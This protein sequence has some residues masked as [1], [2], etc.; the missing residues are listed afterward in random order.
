MTTS[1][2]GKIT[3]VGLGPGHPDQLTLQA[4]KFLNTAQHV[5]VRTERHPTLTAFAQHGTWTYFDDYYE[6]HPD[7]ADVYAAIVQTLITAAQSGQDLA[8]A[9]PGHPHVAE[10]TVTLLIEAAQ[11]A[12]IAYDV[13][14]GVSFIEP[15]LS[16]LNVDALPGLVI[17]DALDVVNLY[18][19]PFDVHLPVLVPQLYSRL[20][21]SDV[22]MTLMN[23]YPDEHEV[24][25]L[26]AAG[27]P[28]QVVA[29]IPLHE[30][31]HSDSIDHLTTLFVPAMQN[32][33]SFADLAN[34][35]AHL[36]APD[37]CPWDQKQ[38]HE[39]LRKDLL[40]ETYE[41]IDAIDR[42][43]IEDLQEELGD[44]L[45]HILMQTQI[46]TEDFE[47]TLSDVVDGINR[48]MI[49]RHP[50][51]FST[52]AVADAD[53]VAQNWQQL[54]AAEK[55]EQGKVEGLLDNIPLSS[56]AL[57]QAYDIQARAAR[58]GFDWDDIQPVLAKISEEFEEVKTAPTAVDQ[59]GEIGDLLFAIVNWARW[60]K[61]DPE[62][63]L[64]GTNT[65]FKARFGMIETILQ[66]QDVAMDDVYLEDLDLLWD[67]AKIN[68]R[69]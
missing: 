67:V 8:Y 43:N 38:T 47:F 46:A 32:K 34:T 28:E 60:L 39:S 18:H 26:Y 57:V 37:G 41:V 69:D 21:A 6:T 65:R 13:I 48:K 9:V 50:H 45:L 5:Y 56:P 2:T 3:I 64:R 52:A 1:A 23:Q 15:S 19:P 66:L 33:A 17:F 30:I 42:G 35:I 63:A 62:T 31:D 61:I 36:R 16:A 11:Q 24:M 12:E 44:L 20:V 51:V 55:A 53:A 10:S 49:R 68:L 7:F 4:Y 22:K 58:V 29:T 54:K 27:T 25:M 59:A 14:A 40:A